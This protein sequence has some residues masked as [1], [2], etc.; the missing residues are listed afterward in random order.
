MLFRHPR[1]MK[2]LCVDKIANEKH[3]NRYD[4]VNFVGWFLLTFHL[5]SVNRST[6]TGPIN[7]DGNSGEFA[8]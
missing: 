7:P 1:W 2:L 6:T 5:I 3:E 8:V 4:F